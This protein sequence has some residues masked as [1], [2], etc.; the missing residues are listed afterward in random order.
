[1]IKKKVM[2][3]LK[4]FSAEAFSS[5]ISYS[6]DIYKLGI[7]RGLFADLD[8]VYNDSWRNK[9]LPHLVMSDFIMISMDIQE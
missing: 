9:Q 2:K 7:P 5:C 1:M 6:E 8:T 3:S 4:T